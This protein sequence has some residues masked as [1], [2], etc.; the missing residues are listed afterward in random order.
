MWLL[1]PNPARWHWQAWLSRA[2][3]LIAAGV[4]RSPSAN[5]R[6]TQTQSRHE[7]RKAMP[8]S[9]LVFSASLFFCGLRFLVRLG[10]RPDFGQRLIG[11][12]VRVGQDVVVNALRDD[13]RVMD[14]RQ[15]RNGEHFL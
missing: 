12:D 11:Q 10:R 5:R 6:P 7:A 9:P 13:L 14:A 15:H 3:P 4:G 1:F 2:W 8:F